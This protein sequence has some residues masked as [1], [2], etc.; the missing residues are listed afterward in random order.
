MK[1]RTIHRRVLR[2]EIGLWSK[3]ALAG[4]VIVSV[5]V[6]FEPHP[7]LKGLVAGVGAAII[8]GGIAWLIVLLSGTGPLM[9]G[10]LAELWTASA[11]RPLRAHGWKLA[12]HVLFND[13]DADHVLIGPGG[14]LVLE[15]K[16]RREAW[17][18]EGFDADRDAATAQ[19]QERARSVGLLLGQ[20]DVTPRPVIV[21]WVG[22]GSEKSQSNTPKRYGTTTVVPGDQLA[23]WAMRL[24]RDVLT[25][26]QVDAGWA[27]L[28]KHAERNEAYEDT[29]TPVPNSVD[30]VALRLLG[31][32]L[33]ALVSFLLLAGLLSWLGS[34][35]TWAAA[36]VTVAVLALLAR[37]RVRTRRKVF[38]T[39]IAIGSIAS[40]IY[41]FSFAAYASLS[42]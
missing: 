24:G 18:V 36:S 5:A 1:A 8:I 42:G 11:L 2:E 41:A 37:S 32:V 33:T 39:A 20:A 6:A 10:E 28:A 35:Y 13:G 16:W 26:A 29:H 25:P 3:L 31:A 21:R 27:A 40:P 15:T 17:R 38:L 23:D 30:E 12:N 4:T 19:V 34:L 9:M 14:V 7:F 22:R